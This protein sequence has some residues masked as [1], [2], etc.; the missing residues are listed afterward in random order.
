MKILRLIPALMLLVMIS[1]ESGEFNKTLMD[2]TIRFKGSVSSNEA[3][4]TLSTRLVNDKWE[5]GDALGIY[6]KVSG[7]EF[8]T[9]SLIASN[10]KYVTN[11]DG[12]FEPAKAAD[13]LMYPL[14][15][16]KVDFVAIHPYKTIGSSHEYNIDI[17]NQTKQTALDFILSNNA[18]GLNNDDKVV[19]LKF[20]RRMV[21]VI[22]NLIT[23]KALEGNAKVTIQNVYKKGVFSLVDNQLVQSSKGNVVMKIDRKK[24]VAEAIVMPAE[25]VDDICIE[26]VN[27]TRGYTF[28]LCDAKSITDLAAGYEYTFNVTLNEDKPEL[29]IDV[30]ATV[31]NW[32]KG[33][34]E[35]VSLSQDFDVEYDGSDGNDDAEN[36]IGEPGDGSEE[37]P[38]TI[39]QA[40][41]MMDIEDVWVKGYIVGYY[42]G[43]SAGS[44]VSA[45]EIDFNDVI[46]DTHIALA[47]SPNETDG[48]K[49]FVVELQN[50]KPKEG[51]NLVDNPHILQ[52]KVKVYGSIVK[53]FGVGMKKTKDY[54][55]LD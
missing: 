8:S 39:E 7:K 25:S 15:N 36:D 2:R 23:N 27:G 28:E 51:L 12:E 19:E 41:N 54:E 42:A 49:T 16:K 22:V 21:K 5:K 40:Q 48:E 45:D 43:T 32:L 38:Y 9:G 3:T 14:D 44:F 24:A 30:Q 18:T 35:D 17:G 29:E 47:D 37:M 13:E 4:E 10:M 26:V 20:E 46:K 1:C 34:T 52:K 31:N 11:G 53:Y 50:K 55:F 6:M 33:E